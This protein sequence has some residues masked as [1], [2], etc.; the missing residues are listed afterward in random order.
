MGFGST[1]LV[2]TSA[3]RPTRTISL[4]CSAAMRASFSFCMR[5]VRIV[6]ETSFSCSSCLSPAS[7]ETI[8]CPMSASSVRSFSLFFSKTASWFL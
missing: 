8:F 1:G 2:G 5:S 6:L 4:F 3:G 7:A